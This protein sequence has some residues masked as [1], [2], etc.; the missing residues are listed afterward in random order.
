MRTEFQWR[1]DR[2]LQPIFSGQDIDAFAIRGRTML[3]PWLLARA[4]DLV[5]ATLNMPLSEAVPNF[6]NTGL[7]ESLSAETPVLARSCI[8]SSTGHRHKIFVHDSDLRQYRPVGLDACPSV[9]FVFARPS[10]A[11]ESQLS[12]ARTKGSHSFLGN[13][14]PGCSMP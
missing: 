6:K 1:L 8:K 11:V 10:A 14:A 5:G 13:D 3:A 4:F 12:V 9:H 7:S 2:H